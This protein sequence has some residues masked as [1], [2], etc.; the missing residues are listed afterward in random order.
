MSI[1]SYCVLVSSYRIVTKITKIESHGLDYASNRI[2][3][4]LIRYFECIHQRQEQIR[5]QVFTV[6][7]NAL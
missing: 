1:F 3:G 7:G 4:W 6:T 5:V 2:S